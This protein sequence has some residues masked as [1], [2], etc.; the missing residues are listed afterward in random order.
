M[1]HQKEGQCASLIIMFLD[2]QNCDYEIKKFRLETKPD[3]PI[4][5][6]KNEWDWKLKSYTSSVYIYSKGKL[7]ASVHD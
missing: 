3:L 7:F 2:Q 6:N 5:L 4:E 1:I